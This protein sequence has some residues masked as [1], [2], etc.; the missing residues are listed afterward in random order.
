MNKV[1]LKAVQ[2]KGFIKSWTTT[3]ILE[4]VKFWNNHGA[5]ERAKLMKERPTH[6]TAPMKDD[7]FFLEM[8]LQDCKVF[9]KSANLKTFGKFNKREAI[10]E[11]LFLTGRTRSHVWL[12][13]KDERILMIHA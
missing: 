11:G 4:C 2:E 7:D 10:K 12:H 8:V 5:K 9:S 13:F 1:V 6:E 3:N